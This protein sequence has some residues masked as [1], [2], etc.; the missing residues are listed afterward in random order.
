[1]LS[2][3]KFDLRLCANALVYVCADAMY[4]QVDALY[5]LDKCVDLVRASSVPAGINT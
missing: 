3:R 4:V 1:M 2:I 5:T